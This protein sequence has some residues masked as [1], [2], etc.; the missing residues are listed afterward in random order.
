MNKYNQNFQGVY[1]T[2]HRPYPDLEDEVK[3]SYFNVVTKGVIFKLGYFV[4]REV[5]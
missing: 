5:S 2:C 4:K 3:H 1:C